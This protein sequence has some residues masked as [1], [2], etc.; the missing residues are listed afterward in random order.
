[1]A[2]TTVRRQTG[3]S[4]RAARDAVLNGAV[5]AAREAAVGVANRPA[6]VGDHL[7]TTAQ[8]DRLISHH[9]ACNLKG[10]RGWHWT[11]TVARVPR[12]R[13]ATICEVELLP[14]D[15]ALL[16]PDWLPWSE[17]LRPGDVRPGDVLPFKADDPRL[18]AGYTPTGDVEVDEVAIDELALARVRVL[19]PEGRDAAAQR[20][21]D[22]DRGPSSPAAVASKRDCGSCGFLAPLQ[23]ALGQVFGVC[24]GEWSPSDGTVVS[25]D[26]GCGAHSETDVA[27]HPSDWPEPSAIIDETTLEVVDVPRGAPAQAEP[28]AQAEPAGSAEPEA[29]AEPVASVEPE[30]QAEPAAPAEPQASSEP[31][32]S[33]GAAGAA[34]TAEP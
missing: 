21:Y 1:M 3:V 10:Y 18:E 16:A 13:T 22:G 8:A 25:L 34:Q 14:G 29:Q 33:A 11:V 23:G 26:H 32:P 5:D 6:D 20:W 27:P 9:F 12:G 28:E 30:A 31:D 2:S 15:E 17:R 4:A 24:A 7:G 19:S